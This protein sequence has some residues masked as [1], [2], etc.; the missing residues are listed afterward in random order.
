V[1]PAHPAPLGYPVSLVMEVRRY[2]Q[3]GWTIARLLDFIEEEHGV[4]PH[5]STVSRWLDPI[6]ATREAHNSS[7]RSARRRA[8]TTGGRHVRAGRTPEFKLARM[9]ALRERGLTVAGIAIVMSLDYE[10]ITEQQV[11]YA[12]DVGKFPKALTA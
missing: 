8:A 5:Q 1:K 4:R 6:Q 12:L 11:L 10:P 7:V 2:R 3:S 9:Q